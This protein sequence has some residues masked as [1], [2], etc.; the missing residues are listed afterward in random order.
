MKIPSL[1][2]DIHVQTRNRSQ[3]S[4]LDIQ[5]FLG[6]DSLAVHT[7]GTGNY[8]IKVNIDIQIHKKL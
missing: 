8:H 4:D 2:Q 1:A 5:E 7:G 6:I 3:N